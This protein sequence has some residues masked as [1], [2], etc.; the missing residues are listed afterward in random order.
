MINATATS[1]PIAELGKYDIT[2]GVLVGIGATFG[3]Y[4][5]TE[6]LKNRRFKNNVKRLVKNELIFYRKFL[7]DIITKGVIHPNDKTLV[8][9]PYG[10]DMAGRLREMMPDMYGNRHNPNNYPKLTVETK[11]IAFDNNLFYVEQTYNQILTFNEVRGETING[12]G[13]YVYS[14]IGI[15]KLIEQIK[16][17]EK[18]L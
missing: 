3:S 5:L 15:E 16:K 12:V 18:T 7:E 4:W 6:F 13:H 14:K 10:S 11:A 2:I 17:T 8:C 9:I 1:Q